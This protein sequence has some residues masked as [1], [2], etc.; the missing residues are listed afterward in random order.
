MLLLVYI[1]PLHAINPTIYCQYTCFKQSIVFE[2]FRKI[3]LLYLD[4]QHLA[5]VGPA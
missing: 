1:L 5:E 4:V 3:S 2:N